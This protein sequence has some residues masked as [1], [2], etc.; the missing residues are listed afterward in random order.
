[1][2]ALEYLYWKDF[3]D[4]K[5]WRTVIKQTILFYDQE[6]PNLAHLNQ[7]VADEKAARKPCDYHMAPSFNFDDIEYII[8][9]RK[10]DVINFASW[11]ISNGLSCCL[12][13]KIVTVEQIRKDF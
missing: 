9:P 1:M 2:S 10:Q 8:L 12:I 4:E 13:P 11:I 3:Y 5:E 6:A 7:I